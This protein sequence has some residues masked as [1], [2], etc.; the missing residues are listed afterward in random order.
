MNLKIKKESN[1][2]ISH[3]FFLVVYRHTFWLD[4]CRL[5]ASV[6]YFPLQE[7]RG[8]VGINVCLGLFLS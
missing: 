7:A 6:P 3:S 1:K 8:E 5:T 2:H 4:T